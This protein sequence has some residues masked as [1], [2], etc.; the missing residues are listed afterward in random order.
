I[1][2]G[3]IPAAINPKSREQALADIAA[4]CQASLVLLEADAPSMASPLAPFTLRAATALP[5]LDEF[6]LDAPVG[7]GSLDLSAFHHQDPA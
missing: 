7:P 3:A 1:A 6:S 5:F 4:D 2:V